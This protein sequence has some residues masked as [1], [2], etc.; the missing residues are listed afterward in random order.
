MPK[1]LDR[2]ISLIY[3]GTTITTIIMEFLIRITTTVSV[4]R[5]LPRHTAVSLVV[6][7]SISVV[8]GLF[9]WDRYVWL[10]WAESN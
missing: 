9:A 3:R 4:V 6:V 8:D 7:C 10:R 5:E 2:A 1:A